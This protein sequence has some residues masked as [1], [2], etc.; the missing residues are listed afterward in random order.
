[1]QYV[2]PKRQFIQEPYGVTSDKTA[3][4][5]V[6]AVKNSKLKE[7]KTKQSSW[8]LV[9]KRTIPTEQPQLIGEL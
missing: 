7:T 9:F 5:I 8:P 3:C 2:L 4:H 1:M 6:T